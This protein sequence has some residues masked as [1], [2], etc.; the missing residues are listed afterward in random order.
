MKKITRFV[1]T[2]VIA[3]AAASSCMPSVKPEIGF[4]KIFEF[5]RSDVQMKDDYTRVQEDWPARIE[6]SEDCSTTLEYL[7]LLAM[8]EVGEKNV[9]IV[10]TPEGNLMIATLKGAKSQWTA[11]VCAHVS[12]QTDS[13]GQAVN[14]P[15]ASCLAATE[16]LRSLKKTRLRPSPTIRVLISDFDNSRMMMEGYKKF[17]TELEKNKKASKKEKCLLQIHLND[18]CGSDA[19]PRTFTVGEPRDIFISM[20]DALKQYLEPY[21]EYSVVHGPVHDPAYPFPAPLYRYGVEYGSMQDDAAAI[22]SLLLLN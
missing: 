19:E 4:A 22:T 7:T 20:H 16:V 5:C 11:L 1:A 9:E 10:E 17:L 18:V 13:L 15:L 8:R 14:D 21:G 12:Q 6:G 3:A 2:I